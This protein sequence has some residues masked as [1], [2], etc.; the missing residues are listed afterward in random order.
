MNKSDFAEFV[1][2]L[3]ACCAMLS[4]DRYQPNETAAAIF[5]NVVKRHDL[6]TIKSAFAAHCADPQRGRFPPVPADILA[7]IEGAARDDGR[8]EDGEAWANALRASDESATVVWTAET[9]E[10]WGICK[11]VLDAGDE[12]GARM[13]FKSA[14]ARLVGAARAAREPLRWSVSEGYDQAQR[15]DVLRISVEAGRLPAAYLPAPRGPVAGLLEMAQ[16]RG[17]PPAVRARLLQIRTQ[18][19]ADKPD[20]GGSDYAEKLHTADLKAAAA[21]AVERAMRGAQ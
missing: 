11:P 13:A 16:Q 9:A 1:K 21:A 18:I 2:V 20:A 8:P 5:F 10:A 4:R 6:A 3:D 15:D 7:Q 19:A 14:Y 17:C 12:V